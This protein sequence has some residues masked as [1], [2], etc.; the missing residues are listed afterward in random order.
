MRRAVQLR[1][2]LDHGI[3]ATSIHKAIED[4]LE[5]H[6]EERIDTAATEIELLKKSHNLLV[7][8][9]KK[10]L[11]RAL[12]SQMLEHAKKLEFE[13]AAQL[14]DEIDRLRSGEG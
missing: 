10:S 3:T 8:D 13:E 14:R 9:Q 1:Y 11:I 12:E 4:I 5:R 6:R 7:P 2:N